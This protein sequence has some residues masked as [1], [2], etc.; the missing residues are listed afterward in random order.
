MN[1]LND[2]CERC[3]HLLLS[4]L[5]RRGKG[6]ETTAKSLS[7]PDVTITMKIGVFTAVETIFS[8]SVYRTNITRELAKHGVSVVDFEEAVASGQSP[9]LGWDHQAYAGRP[10]QEPFLKT[11]IPCVATQ[12]GARPLVLP[13]H[14]LVRTDEE[15]EK[16]QQLLSDRRHIWSSI[17][18]A[19][20]DYI[21]VSD[22]AKQ[23]VIRTVGLPEENITVIHHGVDHSKFFCQGDPNARR[24]NFLLHISQYQPVKNLDRLLSAYASIPESIRPALHVVSSGYDQSCEIRGLT[25]VAHKVSEEELIQLYHRAKAFI[26]PSLHE[27][28]GFPILEA[29]ACGCPLLTSNVTSCPEIAG[30]AACYVDPRSE[31]SIAEGIV[32]LSSDPALCAVLQKRGLERVK[33]FTWERSAEEHLKVFKNKLHKRAAAH[34]DKMVS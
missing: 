5:D 6:W 26:F 18:K 16:L 24:E 17:D 9:D 20:F 3:Q 25:M 14:E 27:G 32:K 7:Q 4:E 31:E 10:P 21:A 22:Y 30:D 33:Q 23:E 28:F 12:H 19:A 1:L 2:M 34:P 8:M 29:M 15:W 13:R 11:S